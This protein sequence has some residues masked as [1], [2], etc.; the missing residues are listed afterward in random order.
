[1]FLTIID[2]GPSRYAIWR[3]TGTDD[4]PTIVNQ[5]TLIFSELG[6]PEELVMDNGRAFRSQ[7]VSDMLDEWNV[8]PLFRA[9]YRPTGNGIVE[10]NHRTI[11]RIAERC[12]CDP[13]R[14]VF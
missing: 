10:R 8:E 9:A 4:A 11:K 1:M 5:L 3:R 6:P 2:C 13:V 12:R 7:R 14:R